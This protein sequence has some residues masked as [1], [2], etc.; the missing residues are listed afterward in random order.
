MDSYYSSV[1]LTLY[2]FQHKHV[3]YILVT[4]HS[5]LRGWSKGTQTCHMYSGLEIMTCVFIL[6]VIYVN[7]HS[8]VYLMMFS[9]VKVI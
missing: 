2:L 6:N 4:W 9:G 7:S 3:I 1:G 5:I 8:W